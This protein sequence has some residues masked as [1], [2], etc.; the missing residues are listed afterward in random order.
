MEDD[1]YVSF[2]MHKFSEDALKM[3]FFPFSFKDKAKC[4]FNSLEAKTITS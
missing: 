1:A 2:K 3:R 4:W